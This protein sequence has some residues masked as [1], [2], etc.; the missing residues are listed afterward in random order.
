MLEKYKDI[1]TVEDLCKI[2]PIGR[3]TVYNLLRNGTIPNKKIGGK[4]TVSKQNLIE[5]LSE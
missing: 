4:Y 3:S 2:L 1:L 5:F